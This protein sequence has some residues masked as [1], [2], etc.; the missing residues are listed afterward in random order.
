MLKFTP[1]VISPDVIHL[2]LEAAVSDLDEAAGV[3]LAGYR[4]PGITT[5]SS[6]TTVR[7]GDGQSFAIAGLLDD[8]VRGQADQVPFLGSLPVLGLLFQSKAFKREETEL[9]VVVTARLAGPVAPHELPPLPNENEEMDLTNF[10]FFFL[11]GIE[12]FA[13]LHPKVHTDIPGAARGPSGAVG[14]SIE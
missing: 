6:E 4:I 7:L 11:P 1:T 3:T 9:L 14:F 2:K 8:R 10:E 13:P 12:H 5:R